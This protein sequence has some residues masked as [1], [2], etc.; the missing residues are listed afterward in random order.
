MFWYALTVRCKKQQNLPWVSQG[1]QIQQA[2]E[3]VTL[4]TK[5][6]DTLWKETAPKDKER[7]CSIFI[8]SGAGKMSHVC[9]SYEQHTSVYKAISESNFFDLSNMCFWMAG[10]IY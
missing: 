1:D 3:T 6:V 7:A 5:A 9:N 2:T 10:H 8:K 4:F